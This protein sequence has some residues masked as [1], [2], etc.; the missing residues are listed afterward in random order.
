M[1]DTNKKGCIKMTKDLIAYFK[2]ESN[3]ERARAGLQ[4]IKVQNLYVD[5]MPEEDE[6]KEYIPIMP[7]DQQQLAGG[8]SGYSERQAAVMSETEDDG[9]FDGEDDGR[10]ITHMLHAKINEDD[11]NEALNII[12]KSKGYLEKEEK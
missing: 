5:E 12:H 2:T 10:P 9:F 4:R 6:M 1:N 8:L 11:Y 3:A 7:T